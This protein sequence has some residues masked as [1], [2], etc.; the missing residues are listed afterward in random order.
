M[1]LNNEM[2][3]VDLK[4][5][6]LSEVIDSVDVILYSRNIT[7]GDFV[8]LSQNTE[9]ITGYDH[10]EL[11][12]GQ[13]LWEEIIFSK[14]KKIY[15]NAIKKAS[16]GNGNFTAEYKINKKDDSIIDVCDKGR[17]IFDEFSNPIRFAGIIR[18]NSEIKRAENELCR[19]Q[20]LQTLGRLAAGVAH[21]INT[22]IQFIGDNLQ[23]MQDSFCQYKRA[24][25]AYQNF[26]IN[27]DQDSLLKVL[28]SIDLEFLNG[29]IPQALNQ[30]VDGI[31]RVSAMV[32][33]MRHFSHLDERRM[34]AADINK[35][36][37]S[38]L[39]IL[40][41][42]VKYITNIQTNF[43]KNLPKVVCC[44]DEI[45][46]VFMNLVVNAAHSIEQ[47]NAGFNVK[48][49]LIRVSS[50][51]EGK[52][53]VVKVADDGLGIPED[54]QDK[55]FDSFFTTKKIG[56][57]TGQGLSISHSIVTKKHNGKL[58]FETVQGKGTTFIVKIPVNPDYKRER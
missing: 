22:P 47:K 25:M 20:K 43:D 23:F 53:V 18:D 34:V 40:K 51:L 28:N 8:Y 12:S 13:V 54:I 57:G 3:N 7:G 56:K 41:N 49:G 33:A 16:K 48:K 21:E 17:V 19:T 14:N 31:K 29:E 24:L 11:T 46:Q 5:T 10:Q 58:Y 50:Q 26:R 30:S 6:V 2:I 4:E 39:I 35:A 55:I 15:E 42:E 32:S 37:E 45:N 1:E 27:N 36:L 44:I 9:R 52:Y 38:T